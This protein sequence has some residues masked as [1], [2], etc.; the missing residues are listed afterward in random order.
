MDWHRVEGGEESGILGWLSLAAGVLGIVSHGL[1]CVIGGLSL[2]LSA[3]LTALCL[4]LAFVGIRKGT[5]GGDQHTLSYVGL[6]L[7]GVNTAILLVWGFIQ[8]GFF[9][10]I[11]AILM[12]D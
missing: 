9:A 12:V 4:G 6:V 5:P 11:M 10:M 1:C 8:C 3:T 2:A 7:G